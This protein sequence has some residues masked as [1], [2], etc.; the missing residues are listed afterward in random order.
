MYVGTVHSQ[1]IAEV[2]DRAGQGRAGQGRAGQGRTGT[3]R[4]RRRADRAGKQ[5][6]QGRHRH[7]Q[8]IAQ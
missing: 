5:H 2:N 3:G 4:A 8:S 7:R 6:Q 1:C